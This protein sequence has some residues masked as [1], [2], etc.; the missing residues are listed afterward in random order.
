MI[1][2]K[3]LVSQSRSAEAGVFN[4]SAVA[5]AFA[6]STKTGK[7]SASDTDL[8]VLAVSAVPT[9]KLSKLVSCN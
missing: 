7:K 3:K 8:I 2:Y 4:D 6:E 1:N 9:V 5:L